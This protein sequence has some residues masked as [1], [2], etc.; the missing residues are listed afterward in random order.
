[1]AKHTTPIEVS[2][3]APEAPSRWMGLSGSGP[4]PTPQRR[5]PDLRHRS[6]RI[7]GPD[8]RIYVSE[9]GGFGKDGDGKVTAIGPDGKAM[10]FASGMDDPKGLAAIGNDDLRRRQD[11]HL[12]DRR[13]G[14]GIGL[15]QGRRLSAAAPVS[16]RPDGRPQA[17]TS[18]SPTAVISRRAGRGRSSRLRRRARCR[19]SSRKRRTRPSRARMGCSSNRPASCS[20]WTSPAATCCGWTSAS[21]RPRR[22]PRASVA[23][24]DSPEAPEACCT[25]RTGRT[26]ASG[27]ST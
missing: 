19:W 8:G 11:A 13:K 15:R 14:H 17:G 10:P 20:S 23:A 16:Q 3:S 4:Q 27:S 21:G 25:C 24:M 5:S 12:E 9:I 1:M 26:G 18:S 22:S 2:L 6:R 7:I